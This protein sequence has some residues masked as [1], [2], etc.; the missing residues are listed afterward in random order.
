MRLCK[1]KGSEMNK[2][3]FVVILLIIIVV[4]GAGLLYFGAEDAGEEK[5]TP[6]RSAVVNS[7]DEALI[8]PDG[9]I[10]T[11]IIENELTLE[12]KLEDV[13]GGSSSGVAYL[14]RDSDKLDHLIDATLPDLSDNEFYEGW[15]VKKK[16]TLVFFSTG[17]MTKQEDGNF[18]LIY[19]SNNLYAGHDEVVITRE[20]VDDKT[21]EEHILEGIIK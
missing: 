11:R 19:S 6:K 16:P 21:P 5:A 7:D 17:K 4:L 3:A 13:S 2:V 12:G 1:Q 8:V 9:D 10:L 20:I 15:L 18:Q 14:L